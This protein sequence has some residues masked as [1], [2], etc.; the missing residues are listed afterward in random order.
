MNLYRADHVGSLLRPQAL[1]D[2]HQ[3]HAQGRLTLEALRESEDRAIL[4]ALA[5]QREVGIDVLSDGELRRRSWSSDFVDAV[6][7]YIPGEA[8]V[9]LEWHT[10]EP[11]DAPAASG[12]PPTQIIGARLQQKRRLTAHESL[13]L[14]AHA[15]TMPY[16]VTLPAAS[17]VVTR[18]YKPG[19]TDKV[20]SSRSE[21]LNDAARIIREE[22]QA[23][24]AEGVPYIQL[25]NPHYPDYIM[26]SRRAQWRA[27]G[28][29]PE[30]SLAEDIAADNASIAGV[31]RSRTV[32]AMHFCRGN[33]GRG[34]W[35]TTGGYDAIAEQV[36]GQ[37]KVD[38][39]LLEYD[40][41]RAGG[42]EPLRF[43]P[44]GV[45]AVLGLITTKAGT[46]ESREL[47]LRRIDEAA[48]YLP[49]ESLALSPQCGFASVMS[50]NPLS[51]EEQRRKLE[52]VV[53]V[54]RSLW[55]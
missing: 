29:D 26:E 21:V 27:I 9:R 16:K 10:A 17:Y 53:S 35:H 25:D 55:S 54:A 19:V 5:L 20:Y 45:I 31:D 43:V 15:G 1:L 36:F 18:G 4:E 33:G 46:L 37:L 7:G 2:A 22:I 23:L 48:K 11:A 28:L 8:P 34:G 13:F 47:I 38:R 44:K 6:D 39:L 50:G 51:F 30:Q 32:L 3:A 49:L 41:E 12:G 40:S 14:R 52:L 42:F 24:I